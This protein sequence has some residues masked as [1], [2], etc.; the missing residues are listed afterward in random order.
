[1]KVNDW[2]TQATQTLEQVGIGSARLDALILLEGSL[3][4]D[5][6]YL[7]AN[8]DIKLN[9]VIL[10]KLSKLLDR[11]SAHEPL[12]YIRGFAEFYARNFEV[13]KNVLVPRL[14]SETMIE[15]LLKLNL[16][17]RSI[18]LDVGTGSGALAITAKLELPEA[19]VIAT[20]ID[21]K[22]LKVAESN[23][24]QL[25]AEIEFIE[26]DLLDCLQTKNYQ[27][28]TVLAN[29]PYVPDNYRINQAATNE[30]SLALF[31]GPD[32]LG[33]YRKMFNQI[34]SLDQKPRYIITEAL[35]NQ[36]VAL[37]QVAN[38]ASYKETARRDLIQ[39]FELSR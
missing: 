20:D 17:A 19:K 21:P 29:L 31:G 11:R 39:L 34:L 35:T 37:A 33:L 18:I 14:E 10:N 27:L 24:E 23:A 5:R 7:L 1:M 15:L 36:H 3:G 38:M 22:C 4:K 16:S 25:R 2:L 8:P 30:P 26:S 9:E 6:S 28:T 12:A 32:G 13:N